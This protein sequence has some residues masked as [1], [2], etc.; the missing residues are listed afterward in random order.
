MIWFFNSFYFSLS[1]GMDPHD[2]ID[3]INDGSI[4]VPE[5]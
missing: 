2:V 5:E 1:L 4:E 3:G